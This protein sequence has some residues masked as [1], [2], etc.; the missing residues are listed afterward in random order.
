M[1]NYTKQS[2]DVADALNRIQDFAENFLT[3][4]TNRR[5]QLGRE[6]ESRMVSAYSYLIGNEN[7][8]I[9][10]LEMALEAITNNL[11]ERGVELS[12]VSPEFRTMGAQPILAAANESAANIASVKLEGSQNYRERLENKKREA[13][14]ILRHINM[15]DDALSLIDPSY[16]GNKKLIEADDV[17]EAYNRFISGMDDELAKE[18]L[19]SEAFLKERTEYLQTTEGLEGL[20]G[21]VKQDHLSAIE[22]YK[23]PR[24]Q[25]ID[26][27]K[28]HT[29]DPAMVLSRHFRSIGVLRAQLGEETVTSKKDALELEIQNQYADLGSLLYPQIKDSE[30]NWV[31]PTPETSAYM[32]RQLSESLLLL[33]QDGDPTEFV[34]YLENVQLYY[35]EVKKDDSDIGQAVSNRVRNEV[36]NLLGI[37]LEAPIK[38]GEEFMTQIE[39]ILLEYK[40]LERIDLEQFFHG[41]MV[42]GGMPSNVSFDVLPSDPTESKADIFGRAKLKQ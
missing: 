40:E 41:T 34:L 21:S 20:R 7:D 32:A 12:S 2:S 25:T 33:Q 8:Q 29:Q 27:L 31:T 10:E 1:A 24:Q 39:L 15:Y 13:D 3:M 5:V 30:G 4:E 28:M 16:A 23:I 26:V 36:L 42:T 17:A 14:K 19:D 37:D 6:K 22:A 35:D 9:D 11:A 38:F 18:M